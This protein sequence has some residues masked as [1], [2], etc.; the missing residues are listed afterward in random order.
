VVD[1]SN[2]KPGD[3]II[4]LAS[5]GLHSNGFSLV[6]KVFLERRGYSLDRHVAA[7]GKTLGEELLTPTAIYVRPVLDVSRAV[8][9]L[10][11][12]HITGGGFFGNIPR[13]LPQTC[14]ATIRRGSWTIPPIFP[15][16]QRDAGLDDEEM[17]GTFN[18]GVGM[19]VIVRSDMV[20]AARDK[21]S[22]H[23]VL[24]WI[25]GEIDARS[26]PDRAV[27]FL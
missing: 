21:F 15:M 7:L 6:R 19:V 3:V 2:V 24:S 26:R 13:V 8:P 16:L 25:I 4:G 10:A 20:D 27:R 17:F 9:A 23:Q 12:A 1:G 11:M 5:S 14:C 18:M 22:E